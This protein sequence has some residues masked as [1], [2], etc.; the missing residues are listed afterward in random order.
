MK[1]IK[2]VK[3]WSYVDSEGMLVNRAWP[4]GLHAQCIKPMGGKVVRVE[5]RVVER[6]TC[7]PK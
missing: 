7:L 5:I 6:K 4:T 3:A 1:K 2:P